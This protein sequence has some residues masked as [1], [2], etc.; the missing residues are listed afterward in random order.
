MQKN[1]TTIAIAAA[2]TVY[3]FWGF[4]FMASAIAQEYVTPFI[5]LA[6]RF[7]LSALILSFPLIIGKK[8]LNF[9][10][11][12][13]K[14]LFLLG[15]LEPCL[16][17]IGEQYGVKYTNS[18][19]SGI[20][21]ALIPI[22]TLFLAAVVLKETPT[23]AQWFFSVL[24]IAGIIVITLSESSG[25]Q[26]NL[27]GFLCLLVAVVT[28]SFYTIVSKKISDEFSVYERTLIMQI[29]AAVFYTVLSL[30]ECREN[31]AALIEPVKNVDFILAV[32]YLAVLGSV[33]GYSL[34]NYAIANAPTARIVVLCNLTTVISV[35]AG[36]IFLGEPFGIASAIGIIAVLT[37]IWGVQRFS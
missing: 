1:K 35:L 33:L 19:F 30:I 34:F 15:L 23:K 36:V 27:L 11:K 9:K 3:I 6:Y 22:A 20:M 8:K 31:L 28:G 14:N 7:V 37:G 21:I 17:F 13:L 10:G 12:K 24:S 18:S 29:M 4:T 16:Y 2:V 26:V 25:G 32:L 5:L